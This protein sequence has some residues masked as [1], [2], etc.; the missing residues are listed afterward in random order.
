MYG[1][2]FDYTGQQPDVDRDILQKIMDDTRNNTSQYTAQGFPDSDMGDRLEA[3]GVGNVG[4]FLNEAYTPFIPEATPSYS[5]FMADTPQNI[6]NAI[7]SVQAQY[8]VGR[9]SRTADFQSLLND[10]KTYTYGD[11]DAFANAGSGAIP[12]TVDLDNL[13]GNNA[14]DAEIESLRIKRVKALDGE[15]LD[16]FTDTFGKSFGLSDYDK[17]I[18]GGQSEKVI[19]DRINQYAKEGGN[20]GSGV[21]QM[22]FFEPRPTIGSFMKGSGFGQQDKKRAKEAGYSNSEIRDW[23]QKTGN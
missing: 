17:L 3:V 18:A 23:R 21:K 10:V 15:P 16:Y 6:A 12:N 14:A 2:N 22:D 8:Q 9:D 5:D 20:F 1:N 7:G 13:N 11:D 4:D 19:Q